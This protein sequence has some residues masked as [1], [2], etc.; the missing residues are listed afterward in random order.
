LPGVSKPTNV[1]GTVALRAPFCE[2][3]MHL[4]LSDVEQRQLVETTRVLLSPLEEPVH[5]WRARVLD[6][7]SSLLGAAM[8]GFI[9]PAA[10]GPPYTLH[11]LPDEFAREYFESFG[12]GE[13]GLAMIRVTTADVWSTR[14]LIRGSGSSIEDGWFGSREYR[15][16]YSRYGIEEGIG[17]VVRATEPP[18]PIGASEAG[19]AGTSLGAVLTCFHSE[20]GTDN[21]DGRGL[22]ILRML[23]PAL[24]AGVAGRV[25]LGW[26]ENT[27]QEAFDTVRD[28]I[29]VCD[30]EGRRLHANAAFL[31][32]LDDDPQS[33]MVRA[34]VERVTGA[35]RGLLRSQQSDP[36]I[37]D[38][39]AAS[40]EITTPRARYQISGQLAGGAGF[41]VGRAIIVSIVQLTPTLPSSVQLQE[42]W[43][44]SPQE[45][46]VALLL[47]QGANNASIAAEM[48]L[49][50]VTVRHYTE[51]VFNKLG[52]HSRS[53]VGHR[54][55]LE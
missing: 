32:M 29:Q 16:F 12:M 4:V 37:T 15:E 34:V 17:Y 22:A 30:A 23:Q 51:S 54:I 27:L 38:I 33:D 44:L 41:G 28:G 47:A 24:E 55:L 36:A 52:V 13:R 43:A 40:A 39:E 14:Q 2:A 7:L 45:A 8:G 48:R 35:L 46:R 1:F 42:R 25:R 26:I 31:R 21:L 5:P 20:F 3:I 11:N 19:M 49:S 10:D 9:L 6:H 50:P 18:L 53:A